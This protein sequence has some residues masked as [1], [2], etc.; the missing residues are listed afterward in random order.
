MVDK[1]KLDDSV[2]GDN[3][4][5]QKLNRTNLENQQDYSSQPDSPNGKSQ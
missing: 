2:I 3:T 5:R 4:V 1:S